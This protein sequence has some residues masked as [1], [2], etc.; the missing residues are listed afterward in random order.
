MIK[1]L[2]SGKFYMGTCGEPT[3]LIDSFG[4][5]LFVGDLVIAFSVEHCE[6]ISAG[7]PEY[8]VSPEG[9]EPFIMGLKYCERKTHYYR[10]GEEST[11]EIYDWKEDTYDSGNGWMW[12]IKKV[13]GYEITVNGEVWGSGNV[14]VRLEEQ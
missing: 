14:T 5:K 8:I 2:Y 6:E 9:E 12:L 1:K 11:E 7:E 4:N 13:K 3:D 10:D